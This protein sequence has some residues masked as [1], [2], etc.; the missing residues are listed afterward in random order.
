MTDQDI[1]QHFPQPW[2]LS[3]TADATYAKPTLRWLR[4][5]LWPYF[6]DD[7]HAKGLLTWTRRNDCDNF[8][9]AYAQA[10]ADCHGANSGDASEGLAVGEFWYVG[11]EHVKGP[12]AIVVAFTDEGKVFIE[13]QSGQRIALTPEEEN[14]CFL[15]KF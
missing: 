5:V 14:S 2:T 11:K 7:R 4:D 13:P 1:R 3:L 12:H 10:A 9:R 6:K 8:A 15:V